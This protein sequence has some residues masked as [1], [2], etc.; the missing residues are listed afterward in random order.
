VRLGQRHKRLGRFA[1]QITDHAFG[2][3]LNVERALAQIWIVNLAEGFGVIVS[4]FLENPFHITEIA[5]QLA[6]HF[7]YKG[8]I[9]HHQQMGVENGG[10]FAADRFCDPML[11][12][13]DLRTGL[14]ECGFKARDLIGD[15]PGGDAVSRYVVAI[16]LY[17]MD[18]SPSDPRGNARAVIIN[19]LLRTANAHP[20][21]QYSRCQ[22]GG[23]L[24]RVLDCAHRRLSP[25]ASP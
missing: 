12:L 20:L 5:L 7:V 1:L 21:R 14:D 6:E 2:H 25:S 18:L 11:H 13:Q 9:F 24:G 16:V 15:L 19:F 4:H 8:A 10:I 17:D 22:L 3:I 23:S